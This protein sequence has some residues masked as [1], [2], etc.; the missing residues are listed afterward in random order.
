MST[1]AQ[2]TNPVRLMMLAWDIGEELELA[3]QLDP[4]NVDVR[5]DLVRYYTMTPGIAGGSEE[6][7]REQSKALAVR[8]PVLGH[9]ATGYM[10]YRD[11]QFG[12]A[13]RELTEALA[14]AT[15][16]KQ[17]VLIL[18]WLGWL[19]QESQQYSTAFDAFQKL[20]D[21]DPSQLQALYEIGRTASF[22]GC[23][24]ERGE[25]AIKRY[26]AAKRT[27]EMPSADDAKKVLAKITTSARQRPEPS[28]R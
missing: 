12:V 8:D 2:T 26:L 15:T 7:A 11:K 13:R 10:A 4:E 23:E 18:P 6:K 25:A 14:L 16:V 20:I 1:A 21:A 17:R 3:L 22:C 28:P 19:S 9:F 5:V 24:L 27:K